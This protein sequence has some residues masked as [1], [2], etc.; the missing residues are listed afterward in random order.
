MRP[1][2][3]AAREVAQFGKPLPRE[4]GAD[5]RAPDSV[6][7]HEDDLF[8]RAERARPF[9]KAAQGQKARALNPRQLM[10]QRL[11]HVNQRHALARLHPRTELCRSNR[12]VIHVS[13]KLRI[14]RYFKL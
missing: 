5:L 10:L 6:M 14:K 13:L 12:L 7:A 9:L 2:I 1:A 4:I 11:A 3:N 8:V